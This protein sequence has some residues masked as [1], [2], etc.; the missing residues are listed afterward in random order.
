[1]RVAIIISG[2][3]RFQKAD[4]ES[5]FTQF[6]GADRIDWFFIFGKIMKK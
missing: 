3:P 2:Q 4:F 6:K 5:H 1:M